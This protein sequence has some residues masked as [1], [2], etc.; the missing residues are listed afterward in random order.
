MNEARMGEKVRR[1][2]VAQSDAE[3]RKL[4]KKKFHKSAALNVYLFFLQMWKERKKQTL[5]RVKL[6]SNQFS[7]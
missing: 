1:M 2:D 3:E 4:C 6:F 5:C 7:F